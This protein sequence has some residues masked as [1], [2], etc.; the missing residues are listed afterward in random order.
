MDIISHIF[1]DPFAYDF[2]QRA[3]IVSVLIASCCAV[4]SCFL[5]L[6][7][8][9]LMGDAISHALL[10]GLVI[11]AILPAPL[12]LG[13]FAAGLLCALSIGALKQNSRVKEDA[14]MGIVFSGMFALGLVMITHVET[15]LHLMHIL[16]GNVLGVSPQE[17][18]Q[19]SAL[20]LITIAIILI[21]RKD[22]MLYCFDPVQAKVAGL[23][24]NALHFGLLALLS[25][26]IVASLKASGLILVVA[27]LI[28]PG[29]SAFLLSKSFGKMMVIALIIAI[30]SALSGLLLSFHYDT[31][32][33]PMMVCMQS[34]IFC[35]TLI[36]QS[37]LQT[38]KLS[39]H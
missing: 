5:V 10:P 16:F 24:V 3:A 14:V 20:C 29:A 7:G 18:V 39:I 2:M 12:L 34:A 4:F 26:T 25:L 15:D 35:V 9:S 36:T 17:L 37:L 30:C 27:M 28:A 31:A 21:K 23:N 8:W 19:I 33:A 6:K 38:Q 32:T 22:F 1:L 13:A 11:A